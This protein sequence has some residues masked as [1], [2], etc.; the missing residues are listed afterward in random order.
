MTDKGKNI[1]QEEKEDDDGDDLGAQERL[2]IEADYTVFF[3][4]FFLQES[5]TNVFL[6]CDQYT[7]RHSGCDWSLV[8]L[9]PVKM[10]L[11]YCLLNRGIRLGARLIS[12][13]SAE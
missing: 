12:G 1:R 8:A 11:S 3:L 2:H 4:F 9:L 6:L 7:V 10:L 13:T 5:Q